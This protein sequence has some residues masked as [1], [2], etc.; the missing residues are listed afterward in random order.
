[1]NHHSRCSIFDWRIRRDEDGWW[2]LM[3]DS[4]GWMMEDGSD[5]FMFRQGSQMCDWKFW[6]T[7]LERNVSFLSMFL[8]KIAKK[9]F[10]KDSI[11][12]TCLYCWCDPIF[13]DWFGKRAP[14]SVSGSKPDLWGLYLLMSSTQYLRPKLFFCCGL[15]MFLLWREKNARIHWLGKDFSSEL[16]GSPY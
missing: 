16:P 15:E 2:G 12:Q 7:H 6:K 1:M 11:M 5:S 10:F 13:A 4:S 14:N 3:V 8:G 9:F